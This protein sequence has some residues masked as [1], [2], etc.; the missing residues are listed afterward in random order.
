MQIVKKR[1]K[2]S[3]DDT[4]NKKVIHD[5]QIVPVQVFFSKP[6]RIKECTIYLLVPR[7]NSGT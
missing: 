1:V 4:K 6:F 2:N 3:G 5:N 7:K